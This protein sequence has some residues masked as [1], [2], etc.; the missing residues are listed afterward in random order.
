MDIKKL[1]KDMY[2]NV[3]NLF[4]IILLTGYH[5]LSSYEKKHILALCI[6]NM[7][8]E[9]YLNENLMNINCIKQ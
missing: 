1:L 2:F 3:L 4:F 6:K 8:S 5:T 9:F 7:S